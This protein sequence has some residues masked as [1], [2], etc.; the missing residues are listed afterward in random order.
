MKS[1][2]RQFMEPQT[3]CAIFEIENSLLSR[4]WNIGKSESSNLR[5]LNYR[6]QMQVLADKILC[7]F[8]Y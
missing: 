1:E 6:K 7:V 3:A 5:D 2:V 8:V 4:E